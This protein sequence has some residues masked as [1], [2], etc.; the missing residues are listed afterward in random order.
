MKPALS[1]K[2]PD[3]LIIKEIGYAYFKEKDYKNAISTY[4]NGLSYM[5]DNVKSDTKGEMAF[6]MAN[7]Y[8]A[9]GN[10]EEY[11]NWMAKAKLYAPDN[12]NIYRQITAAGF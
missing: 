6:N 5:P 9:E 7:I 12:S 11:Q 8:K 3:P 2:S 1:N 10:H 4:K